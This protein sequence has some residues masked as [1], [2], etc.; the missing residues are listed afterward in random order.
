LALATVGGLGGLFVAW[1]G[2]RALGAVQPQDIPHTG[3]I[4]VD[5]RVL[6]YTSC[7]IAACTL[8]VAALPAWRLSRASMYSLLRDGGRGAGGLTK[9]RARHVLVI[10]ETALA[11]LLLVG[12]SLFVHSFVNL[13]R[14]DTGFRATPALTFGLTL[15]SAGYDDARNREFYRQLF[16]RISQIPGVRAAGAVSLL[17][18]SRSTMLLPFHVQGADPSADS[19][20]LISTVVV[21][22]GYFDAMGIEI[23]H[24]RAIE[25]HAPDAPQSVVLS[26]SAVRQ[27]LHDR[28]PLEAVVQLGW[29]WSGTTPIGGRVVGVARNVRTSIVDEAR[30]TIYVEHS[31]APLSTM[32]V[33]VRV[34]RE[35]ER[36]VAPIRT[37]LRTMDAGVAMANV[38]TTDELVA[39]ATAEPRFYTTL[40]SV[41]AIIALALA[42]LGL[43]GVISYTVALR[44]RE[45][46]IRMALGANA[47]TV[48]KV[49][50]VEGLS[51]AGLGLAIGIAIAFASSRVLRGVLY[52]VNAAE[53]SAY[54]I[55]VGV[56]GLFAA[57]GALVPAIRAA[58][59]DPSVALRTDVT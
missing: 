37:I 38:R 32:N 47:S 51:I 39:G 4:G 35:P 9:S 46:G 6:L 5:G 19:L 7:V 36:Y 57:L 22:P 13:R 33:V 21:T 11:A 55:A 44:T 56:L 16:D 20:A 58:R 12:A 52:N 10:A 42:I 54:V 15:P 14:V 34:D 50:L 25:R 29:T 28:R 59:V 18:L 2:A 17:P 31:A 40:L 3:S 30:P 1:A 49:V 24:G 23:T 41:F 48:A 53:P 26:E 8:L 43:F 27:G 45:I